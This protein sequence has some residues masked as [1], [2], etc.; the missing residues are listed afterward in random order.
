[1]VNEEDTTRHIAI[2]CQGGG[3]HTA[4]TAGVLKKILKENEKKYTIVALSGTSGGAI[5]ALLAWYG[6]L[7]EGNDKAVRLLDSFWKDNSAS[8]FGDMLVNEWVVGIS[9]LQDTITLPGVSPYCYPPWAQIYL[10]SLLERQVDFDKIKTFTNPCPELLV[11]AVEVRSGRFCVF[12]NDEIS[13][14]VILASAAIPTFL[15]AVQ[16]DKNMYWDGLFSQNPPVRDFVDGVDVKPDEIWVIQINPENRETLPESV[17]DIQDRRNEL[18]GNLSLNQEI[19][20][21]KKVNEWID[22]GYFKGSKYKPIVVRCIKMLRDLDASSKLDRSPA[23]IED[24]MAYGEK[25]AERFLM[26]MPSDCYP[27]GSLQTQV[28]HRTKKPLLQFTSHTR[29]A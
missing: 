16:I 24:M 23:F 9:R 20:F 4:F 12:K 25:Q 3:S 8:T 29:M 28:H 26:Q 13:A 11:G 2:A 14:D 21:I 10:K 17:K 22:K 18:A 19:Y 6:M 5:C 15:R 27:E 1:M 7:T